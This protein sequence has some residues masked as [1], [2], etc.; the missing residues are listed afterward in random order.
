VLEGEFTKLEATT[1]LLLTVGD[2][3]EVE[4]EVD[5]S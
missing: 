4:V 5:N 2:V 1:K 3:I